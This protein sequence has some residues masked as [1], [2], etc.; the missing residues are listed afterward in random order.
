MSERGLHRLGG[1]CSWLGQHQ[2]CLRWLRRVRNAES[3]AQHGCHVLRSRCE[4]TPKIGAVHSQVQVENTLIISLL[5][6]AYIHVHVWFL[7]IYFRTSLDQP[8]SVKDREILLASQLNAGDVIRG[9]VMKA[10]DSS[11]TVVYEC[12]SHVVW[13]YFVIGWIFSS[14]TYFSQAWSQNSRSGR[15]S[16][17]RRQD[18]YGH[19][20]HGGSVDVRARRR[21]PT[22]YDNL[23]TIAERTFLC[24]LVLGTR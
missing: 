8:V 18:W 11:F 5:K 4:Q 13:L 7:H 22:V 21:Y 20:C 15:G 2:W 9:I 14:L 1:R 19:G 12:Y 10:D 16:C 6:S 17:K 23:S 3:S 24:C